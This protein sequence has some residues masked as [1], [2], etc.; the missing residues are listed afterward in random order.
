VLADHFCER[1]VLGLVGI[2]GLKVL[3][4]LLPELLGLA[5]CDFVG[6]GFF[7]NLRGVDSETLG[8]SVQIRIDGEAD[9][10][11]GCLGILAYGSHA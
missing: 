5:S 10:L 4:D 9:G 1:A 7:S 3:L 8:L 11:L 6:K 2:Q